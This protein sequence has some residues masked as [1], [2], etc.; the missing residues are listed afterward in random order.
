MEGSL[1]VVQTRQ[2]IM[3]SSSK[4]LVLFFLLLQL[5]SMLRA[6]PNNH[7]HKHKHNPKQVPIYLIIYIS[8][9]V[10]GPSGPNGKSFASAD[11]TKPNHLPEETIF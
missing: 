6:A 2:A 1:H 9:E 5:V 11:L 4:K 8:Q 7:S 3:A 10:L